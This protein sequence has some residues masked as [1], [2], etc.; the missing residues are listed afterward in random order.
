MAYERAQQSREEPKGRSMSTGQTAKR[1]ALLL[2]FAVA[3]ASVFVIACGGGDDSGATRPAPTSAQTETR[4]SGRIS[5]F[6][7][8]SL[9]DAFTEIGKAFEQ[10]NPSTS[11]EFN[12]AGSAAL[13]TQIEEG[14][15]ADVFASANTT[16][17]DA[18][19][20]ARLTKGPTIFVHNSLVVITPSDNPASITSLADL[21][22]PGLKLVLAAAE[23]PVGGYA[24]QMLQ[25]ADADAAFGAGFSDAVLANLVSNESNVKQ[26]VA[27]IQLGEGDAGIV[28]GSD[29]TPDVAQELKTI[30]VPSSVNVVADYP[31]ATLT[32]TGNAAVAQAFVDFVLDPDGQAILAKW[33][34]STV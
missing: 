4:L 7:A 14:A 22:K 19:V 6:A 1:R 16:H 24:R 28:Y 32:D 31:I 3:F 34:F 15:P 11:V 29:V 5:V 30:E 20:D 8:A 23:V 12:F 13:R 9:T 18:L 25:N 17:M 27:K 2:A 33:G 10:A 21:K 26:V